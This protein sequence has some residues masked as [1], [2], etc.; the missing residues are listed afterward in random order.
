M[1]SSVDKESGLVE[2]FHAAVV[3]DVTGVVNA[4]E[5]GFVDLVEVDAESYTIHTSTQVSVV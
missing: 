4:E 1:N 2:D 3:E 5:V